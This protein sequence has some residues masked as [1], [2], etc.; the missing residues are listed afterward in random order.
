MHTMVRVKTYTYQTPVYQEILDPHHCPQ[1]PVGS[2]G[3]PR[4]GGQ[5]TGV[6]LDDRWEGE[7]SPT[8]LE[9]DLHERVTCTVKNS[10]N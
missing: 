10:A 7:G 6:G 4:A 5:N 2:N 3:F 1:S 9:E 8:P